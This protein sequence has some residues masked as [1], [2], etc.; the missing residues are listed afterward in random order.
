VTGAELLAQAIKVLVTEVIAEATSQPTHAAMSTAAAAK[1]LGYTPSYVLRIAK[2]GE[3]PSVGEG[4][5]RRFLMTDLEAHRR[6]N[7][8]AARASVSTEDRAASAR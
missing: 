4:R 6:R 5:G 8:R 1:F 2:S 3:L 7:R